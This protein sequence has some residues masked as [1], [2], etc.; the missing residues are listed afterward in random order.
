[1]GPQMLPGNPSTRS[2][3]SHRH[4]S[5]EWGIW[6]SVESPDFAGVR[7]NPAKQDAVKGITQHAESVLG[8]IAI[9]VNE[10]YFDRH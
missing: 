10:R 7:L 4:A 1:M 8:L 2:A 6:R 3:G 9:Q 5:K